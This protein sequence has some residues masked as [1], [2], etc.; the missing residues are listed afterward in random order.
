MSRIRST[1]PPTEILSGERG[2]SLVE[3][4]VGSL[5]ATI[6]LAIVVVWAVTA[7]R[8]DLY[9]EQDFQALNDMRFAK[10][11]MVKELRFAD[12]LVAFSANRVDIWLDLDGSGGGAPDQAGEWVTWQ[13]TGTNLVRFED[14]DASVSKVVLED[15][16]VSDSYLN[17]SGKI[18][19][20]QLTADVGSSSGPDP[21]TIK[22]QVALRNL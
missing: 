18:V 2:I 17:V 11:E 19:E 8:T 13:I 4:M 22:T 12:G 14:N 9:Q 6:T 3:L 20:I 5:V 15:L 21:R 7:S 10:A 16:V 1:R